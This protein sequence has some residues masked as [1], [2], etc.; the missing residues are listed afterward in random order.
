MGNNLAKRRK[1]GGHLGRRS[2]AGVGER[3]GADRQGQEGKLGFGD[4]WG[5]RPVDATSLFLWVV[6]WS[7]GL[8]VA[9]WVPA[10]QWL[11]RAVYWWLCVCVCIHT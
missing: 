2:L 8:E 7:A 5:R 6:W 9:L 4:P 1:A 11:C 10:C 3:K